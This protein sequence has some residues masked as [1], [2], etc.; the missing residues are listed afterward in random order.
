MP[1]GIKYNMELFDKTVLIINPGLQNNMF[2]FTGEA[3]EIIG[4][5]DIEHEF[6]IFISVGL[7]YKFTDMLR[8]EF[9]VKTQTIF[10]YPINIPINYF[11]LKIFFL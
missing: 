8:G 7:E 4:E 5:N 11:G 2:I 1:V 3:A 10:S 9:Y 6:G